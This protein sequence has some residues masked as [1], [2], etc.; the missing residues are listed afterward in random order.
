MGVRSRP[1]P[2]LRGIHLI[3]TRNLSNGQRVSDKFHI[4]FLW[5]NCGNLI[6]RKRGQNNENET[7]VKGKNKNVG[8][9]AH[10]K[11]A[12]VCMHVFVHEVQDGEPQGGKRGE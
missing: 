11:I 6:S 3:T 2:S 1:P 9:T 4:S 5:S 8:K 12:L 10:Q 7:C